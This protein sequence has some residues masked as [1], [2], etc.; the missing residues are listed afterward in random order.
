MCLYELYFVVPNN[1]ILGRS[2]A[3]VKTNYHVG[4]LNKLKHEPQTLHEYSIMQ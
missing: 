4:F 1:E 2:F 3:H